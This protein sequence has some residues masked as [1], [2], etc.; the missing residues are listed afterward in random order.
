MG[1]CDERVELLRNQGDRTMRI[2]VQVRQDVGQDLCSY[3]ISGGIYEENIRVYVSL[4][5]WEICELNSARR[6]FL[7]ADN[8]EALSL[9]RRRGAV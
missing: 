8:R 9:S 3:G 1:R 7:S 5:V 4:T 6:R 2:R